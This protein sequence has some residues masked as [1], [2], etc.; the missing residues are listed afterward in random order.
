MLRR[1]VGAVYKLEIDPTENRDRH[2]K[3]YVEGSVE[4]AVKD[5]QEKSGM[6]SVSEALRQLILDGLTVQGY[7]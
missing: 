4:A 3:T 1:E 5:F 7:C 6:F 2:M